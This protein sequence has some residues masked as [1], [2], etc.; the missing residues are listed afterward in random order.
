[1]V[2]V[3]LLLGLGFEFAAYAGFQDLDEGFFI[4]HQSN[5]FIL[6]F[7]DFTDNSGARYHVHP[8]L[9]GF[10]EILLLLALSVLW[11]VDKKHK[12]DDK[13]QQRKQHRQA[14]AWLCLK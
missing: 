11:N 5:G 3:V 4:Y 10:H 1:M 13:D 9:Q 6:D 12:E 7:S 14:S 8:F 2:A